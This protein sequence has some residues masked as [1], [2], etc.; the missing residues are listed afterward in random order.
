LFYTTSLNPR[1]KSVT[2]C[3]I[4]VLNFNNFG[5]ID[6]IFENTPALKG[7]RVSVIEVTRKGIHFR[8][9]KVFPKNNKNRKNAN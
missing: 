6:R 8:E 9:G 1:S 7:L 5:K 4:V 3:D 2:S